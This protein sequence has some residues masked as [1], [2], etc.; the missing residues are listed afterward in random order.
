VGFVRARRPEQ[1]RLREAAIL[2]AARELAL[3]DG[4]GAVSLAAIAADVGMHKSALLKY[5]GTREEIFLRLAEDEW[6]GWAEQ[7]VTD[8]GAAGA[9]G[10]PDALG[11]SIAGRPLFCQLLT[12][13]TLTLE[14]NVSLDAV[15]RS[16]AAALRATDAVT[17]AVHGVV[18]D[19]DRGSCF[20]LVAGTGVVAAG[21]WQAANPPPVVLAYYAEQ[22]AAGGAPTGFTRLVG[23]DLPS[24]LARFVRVFLAG[25]RAEGGA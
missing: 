15:R 22:A 12:H 23:V 9:A 1:K 13:S 21:L 17:D 20:D 10:L 7:V 8:I 18:P 2:D 16:K 5:F 14:R 11:R 19:L 6:R 24:E 25:L 3:R 4:V